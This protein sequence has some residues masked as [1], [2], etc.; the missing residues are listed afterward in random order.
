MSSSKK[1]IMIA[2]EHVRLEDLAARVSLHPFLVGLN[3]AQLA[4]L[5]DCV[6]PTH[7]EPAQTILHEGEFAD[8]F[9]LIESGKAILE[10]DA[11]LGEPVAMETIGAG[12]LLGWSWMFPPYVW[13]FTARAIEPMDALFLHAARVRKACEH[14]HSLGYALLKRVSAVMMKRLQAA[15]TKM[16]AV[17]AEKEKLQPVIGLSPF[18]EQEMDAPDWD[19]DD[20]VL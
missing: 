14:D 2:E 6:L 4:T 9:Y 3:R 16:V 8:C 15:R 5:A 18:M 19:E 11:R 12:D 10:S 7:F 13:H 17:H 20:I 1:R